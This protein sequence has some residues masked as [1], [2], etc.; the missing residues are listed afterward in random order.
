MERFSR[1]KLA[2][3]KTGLGFWGKVLTACALIFTLAPFILPAIPVGTD[4]PKHVLIATIIN[5]Y[6]SP[7]FQFNKF[8]DVEKGFHATMLG[9]YILAL[10]CRYFDP[11]IGAK[12]YLTAFVVVFWSGG[13]RLMRV[14]GYNTEFAIVFL[15]LA[16]T[17]L[18]FSGLLPFL[19]GIALFP[20][21][22]A[23]ALDARSRI[24]RGVMIAALLVLASA[25]HVV[26]ACAGIL[27]VFVLALC[28]SRERRYW[29]VD[30]AL[31]AP[32]FLMVLLT[33]L[34]R[35]EADNHFY[36]RSSLAGQIEQYLGYNAWTLSRVSSYCFVILT[37]ILAVAVV[38][39]VW[40]RKS[41]LT[42][43]SLAA[44]LVIVGIAMPVSIGDWFIVGARTFPFAAVL[45]IASLR[46]SERARKVGMMIAVVFLL[47][48]G[49]LN[50]RAVLAVQPL[51]RSFLAGMDS[52]A[53]GSRIL[54]IIGDFT[55]GGNQYIQPFGG[56]DD[57]YNI[58]RGGENPYVLASAANG[59]GTKTTA[60][61][62]RY[63]SFPGYAYK[64]S[65]APHDYHG[66]CKVFDYAVL[67]DQLPEQLPGLEVG[68]SQIFRRQDLIILKY[69]KS[70]C[71]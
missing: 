21:L 62:F 47:I 54:P 1:E 18:V 49:T 41:R 48:S 39:Q 63:K 29:W 69:D 35:N 36:W 5:N 65:H 28:A 52:V 61:I 6:N 31:A 27:V 42:L 33:V 71:E 60:T 9:E 20:F 11:F 7:V 13:R 34:H 50:T 23:F 44:L 25:F 67:F 17:F 57:A 68:A 12:I 53:M 38:S 43:V 8:F 22:L 37:A 46:L 58:Y 45:G 26:A 24:F 40:R 55:L 10:F 30:L 2:A 16:H 66:A 19:A 51:Y 32:A 70:K 4:L 15:P 56:I 64:F 59:G 14:L 3:E